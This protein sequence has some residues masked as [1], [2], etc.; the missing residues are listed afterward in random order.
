MVPLA[1]VVELGVNCTEKVTFCPAARVSGAAKPLIA[2]PVPETAADD[3]V[4]AAFPV[5]VKVTFCE[6]DCP[7]VM[8]LK[9]SAEGLIENAGCMPV[10]LKGMAIVALLA[11]LTMVKVPEAAPGDCGAN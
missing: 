3:T 6:L 8:L 11:L 10:P 5:F 4:K 2:N 7:T 1:P 9:V